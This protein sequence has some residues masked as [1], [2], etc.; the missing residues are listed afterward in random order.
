[1]LSGF[2]TADTFLQYA[3]LWKIGAQGQKTTL[4][5]A[6]P[7]TFSPLSSLALVV[8]ECFLLQN[9]ILMLELVG[10]VLHFEISVVRLS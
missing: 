5:P 10:G 8:E 6:P 9:R 4:T 2:T 1:M 3:A 7:A